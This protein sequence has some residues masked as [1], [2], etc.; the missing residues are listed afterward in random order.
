VYLLSLIS[1]ELFSEH[2]DR[3]SRVT[4]AVSLRYYLVVQ[5]GLGYWLKLCFYF[6]RFF[7]KGGDYAIGISINIATAV[8]KGIYERLCWIYIT[9][10]TVNTLVYDQ[11]GINFNLVVPITSQN[12]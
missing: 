5:T 3:L 11:V 12:S 4:L 8:M 10:I 9:V 1:R 6:D 2:L 7:R